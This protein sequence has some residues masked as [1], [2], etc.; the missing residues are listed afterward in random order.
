M[1]CREEPMTG[2]GE[3]VAGCSF[4]LCHGPSYQ[5]PER[6][7]KQIIKANKISLEKDQ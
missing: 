1:E 3:K 2:G 4:P 5:D 6:K 7:V